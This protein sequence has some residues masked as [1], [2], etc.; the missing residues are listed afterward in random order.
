MPTGY[1]GG[2]VLQAILGHPKAD[3][4]EIIALVRD[5]SKAK[6]IERL[7]NIKTVVGSLEDDAILIEN[8]AKADIV[9]QHVSSPLQRACPH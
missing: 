2:S 4:F 5:K 8:S 9:F 1:I 7:L 6:A 3:T